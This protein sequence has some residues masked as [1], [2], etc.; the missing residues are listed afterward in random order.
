[1]KAAL[2]LVALALA[3]GPAHAAIELDV[4]KE[5]GSF[6][7]ANIRYDATVGSGADRYLLVSITTAYPA[8]SVTSASFGGVALG[9]L[10]AVDSPSGGCRVEWWGLVAPPEGTYPLAVEL[11]TV[12]SRSGASFLSY[13]GVNQATPLRPL[14]TGTGPAAPSAL[15]VASADG[16]V[17]LDGICGFSPNAVLGTAGRNQVARWHWSIRSLSSAGSQA[18]GAA[19]V[20]MTWTSTGLGDM[21]WAASGLALRPAPSPPPPVSLPPPPSPPEPTTHEVN[22]SVGTAGC[23][24]AG[25]PSAGPLA[26]LALGLLGFWLRRPSRGA[27]EDAG[28]SGPGSRATLR[29]MRPSATASPAPMEVDPDLDEV[30]LARAKAGDPAAQTALVQRYERP[31]FSLLWRIVG[32]E[33]AVVEDL[34]QETFLRVFRALRNFEYDGRARLITWILTIATR[35]ALGH[36]RASRPRRDAASA[37]GSVPTALPRPDQDADRRALALA[38]VQAVDGLGDPFR[39][40]FLLREVH[41]LSYDEIALALEIDLGTVKSRLARARAL[42]QAALAEMHDE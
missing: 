26:L 5:D 38:L 23:G 6:D 18:P 22:L 10:G 42:L 36:L 3:A 19:S 28:T 25:H 34:T 21:E 20:T 40:A 4:A 1:M 24:V 9:S 33:R 35:L 15:T 27:P 13:R 11:N 12:S 2:L 39:A 32:A 7:L 29:L 30:T 14:V 31:V 16:E 41:G 37:P 17:V 8:A